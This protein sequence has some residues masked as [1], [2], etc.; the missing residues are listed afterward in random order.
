MA[1]DQQTEM[2]RQLDSRLK[3][4]T[5]M[6]G[7]QGR[8]VGERLDAAAKAVN[9]VNQRL[10]SLEESNKRIHD[11]G[12]DIASLQEILRAPKL[13]GSLGELFLENLLA[14]ILP[15]RDLYALQHTF[16]SGEKVDAVIFLRDSLMVCVDAKFPLENFKKM[17]E[18]T[19]TE[20]V[21]AKKTAALKKL[22][23]T[24]V[25]KHVD[26][27]ASKYILPAENTLDFALMYIPAENVYY[28]TITR[29]LDQ[30]SHIS[31]YA[32]SK[33]V[34]P[35]SPNTFYIYLQTLLIGLRGMQVEKSAQDILK[36]LSQLKGDF[37][38][39]SESYALVGSHLSHTTSSFQKSEKQLEKMQGKLLHIENPGEKTEV[40]LQIS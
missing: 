25:K 35:V 4:V 15:R 18:S 28:E 33:K 2:R 27:I 40:P 16:K 34:I 31:Q 38:R 20:E 7:H 6:M 39:F 17:I 22:F 11:I 5:D 29:E 37:E 26:A 30:E 24:D 9:T 3:E 23:I 10:S 13:R 12:K 8:G 36:Q 14:Q 19:G 32:L 1:L 21:D